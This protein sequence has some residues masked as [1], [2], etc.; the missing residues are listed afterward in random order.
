MQFVSLT[1]VLRNPFNLENKAKRALCKSQVDEGGGH[2]FDQLMFLVGMDR[3]KVALRSP[4][5]V[6]LFIIC[7]VRFPS[8]WYTVPREDNI[9]LRIH[10]PGEPCDSSRAREISVP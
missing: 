6:V 4:Q 5:H 2:I 9:R 8:L 1:Y 10:N 3:S 7:T